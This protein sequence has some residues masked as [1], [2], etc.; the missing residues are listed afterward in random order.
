MTTINNQTANPTGNQ[1]VELSK[2]TASKDNVRRVESEAGLT[3]LV[4]SIRAHGLLQNLTVRPN[5]KGKYEVVAGARRLAALRSLA[6]E[7]GSGWTKKSS[8]PVLILD[9]HNDTEISLAE[10][11]VRQNMH[12]ADQVEAFRKPNHAADRIAEAVSLDM[13]A[14]FSPGETFLKR[15]T[16]KMMASAVTEAGGAPEI[17]TAILG[18]PKAEAVQTA[19]EALQGKGWLPPALRIQTGT[20]VSPAGAQ[21]AGGVSADADGV[22]GD[23]EPLGDEGEDDGQ[24]LESVHGPDD[25]GG[26]MDSN[27]AMIAAE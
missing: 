9:Q 27:E 10:N 7:K 8:I 13:A 17:A 12:V 15:I 3:E 22:I 11:T 1:T 20:P 19:Q 5:D 23:D 6:S 18:L 24:A 16:K 2:L 26:Q 21:D 14:W 25:D 4:A